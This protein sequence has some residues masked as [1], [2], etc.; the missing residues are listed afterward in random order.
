VK[1]VRAM[2]LGGHGDAMVPLPRYSTVSGIPVTEL[3]APDRLGA[4]IERTRNGG[5]EIVNLLKTG[6]AYYAPSAA[7]A[8]MAGSILRDEKR[9]LPAAT[10]LHGEYGIDG[11]F[12]GVPVKL[13]RGGAE[14][15]VELKLTAEESAALR[16][17]AEK[18]REGVKALGLL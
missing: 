4:L 16:A 6:G 10:L 1:D 9:I 8:A 13:G 3:I 7:V 15:V 2:V 17:S 14:K 12:C 11:V 18:V 5:G